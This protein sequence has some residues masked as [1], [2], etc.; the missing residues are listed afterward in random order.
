MN[1]KNEVFESAPIPRAVA[2]MAIPTMITT[3]VM[4]AYNMA[5]TF[6]IGQTGDPIQVAAVSLAFPVFTVLMSIG[7]L[8]GMGGNSCISRALGAGKLDRV[9]HISAFCF[10]GAFLTGLVISLTIFLFM[11]PVLSL[12]GVSETTHDFSQSYLTFITLGACFVVTAGTCG[13]MLRGEGAATASMVGN[14]IGT[15][16]NI[17]LDPIF[18]L[19]F[20]WGVGG[21]AIATVLGNML[22]CTYYLL[23]FF[24]SNTVLSINPRDIRVGDKIATGVIS[25]GTPNMLNQL[26]MSVSTVVMNTT[27]SKY[28]DIPLAAMNVA[29][30]SNMIVVFLQ[31]GLCMGILPLIGYNYGS[32]NKKRLVGIYRFTAFTTI[33]LGTIL[34]AFMVFARKYVVAAFINDPE[35]ISYGMRMV[36]ALEFSGPVIGMAF[37]SNNTLQGMGKAA[38]SL[39]LTVCRQGFVYI[40]AVII[41]DRLLGLSGVIYAQPISD[42]IM[43]IVGTTICLVTIHRL[44]PSGKYAEGASPDAD[45]SPQSANIPQNDAPALNA[46]TKANA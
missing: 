5:D 45:A 27:I 39:F 22:A 34:T 8:F 41:L 24:R 19:G 11:E 46:K 33:T 29:M 18:I 2:T 3:L 13:N 26:L 42:Y 7:S 1:S 31:M 15:F 30:K 32:G 23:Y 20:G 38:I 43:I 37:L 36:I 25:I 44:K 9:K 17:I 28:G 35:V 6:F 10:Y 14:L 4:V 16:A 21:A 12:I 40:P